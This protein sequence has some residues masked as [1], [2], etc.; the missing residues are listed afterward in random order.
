M[1]Y[2]TYFGY[3]ET[4]FELEK[5]TEEIKI[6]IVDNLSNKIVEFTLPATVIEQIGVT[7][8]HILFLDDARSGYIWLYKMKE[9]SLFVLPLGLPSEAGRD[10]E[11][12]LCL[13]PP[14]FLPFKNIT[15]KSRKMEENDNNDN[16]S[17]N[18]FEARFSHWEDY[19][20][21]GPN[22]PLS[23]PPARRLLACTSFGAF[24][25][26]NYRCVGCSLCSV[27]RCLY[28]NE[29][30]LFYDK[31][32]ENYDQE[33][34]N[35][36]IEKDPSSPYSFIKMP[37]HVRKLTAGND[38]L[39]LFN[40]LGHVYTL[41]TGTRGELGHGCIEQGQW[42]EPK[43]V[44]DLADAGIN[45]TDLSSSL[46]HNIALTDEGD[47]Y[48]WGWNGYGQL[49]ILPEECSIQPTPYPFDLPDILDEK[50]ESINCVG[51][52]SFIKFSNGKNFC[53]GELKKS[54]YMDSKELEG[55][56]STSTIKDF[57]SDDQPEMKRARHH[58]NLHVA[59][60]GCSHGQM[61]TIYE[62][63][64]NVEKQRNVKFD[65]LLCCG[66]FQ[67]IRNHG[68]LHYFHAPPHHRKLGTFYKYYSGEK[69]AP[70]LTLFIGGNHE[71]SGYMAELPY[72]GWVAPNIW[73]M[74][75]A[76]V[77]QFAGLR[78]AGL[79]GIFKSNDYNKGHF[80]RPPFQEHG[81]VVSAY[82]VRSI[83]V[84]RLK[85]L[86]DSKIDICMSHDWP[87]GITDFGDCNWLLK[88]KPYFA[89]D[90]QFN[91]LGNPATMNLLHELKPLHWFAAHLHVRFT[92]VVHHN[93]DDEEKGTQTDEIK[94]SIN[95]SRVTNFLALDKPMGNDNRRRFLEYIDI[96]ISED[97]SM[98]LCYD[99][100]WLAILRTTDHLTKFT[101]RFI[102]L[103]LETP[104]K[105]VEE[106]TERFD[107]RPT[108]EELE[109]VNTLFSSDFH[110]P[111][112]FQR[113][114]PPEI[115]PLIGKGKPNRQPSLYYRNPQSQQFCEKL[116]IQDLNFQFAQASVNYLGIPY[117]LSENTQLSISE[118]ISTKTTNE[119]TNNGKNP[120]EIDL[121]EDEFG[122]ND[123][124]VDVKG[125]LKNSEN[126]EK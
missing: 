121:E 46:W 26:I 105:N 79:S 124:I 116:G 67:A 50:V 30:P 73:Y 43:I 104:S 90:I 68:D 66:D 52:N 53:F 109:T 101:D 31:P 14:I 49:G 62:R 89:E 92:A 81:S 78:I 102:N 126:D 40:P 88:R 3:I 18:T 65:L 35:L 85:Q 61:D 94:S 59:V 75:Y 36:L 71:S 76:S 107:F 106:I 72:G 57:E 95:S 33:S 39:A 20:K 11:K 19:Q 119:S 108:K 37:F 99:P 4:D 6:T 44:S 13:K 91:R 64:T 47:I 96:P 2:L 21:L 125:S 17:L 8:Q 58:R 114:A 28:K 110:I 87:A 34:F 22:P 51:N 74:G 9:E 10:I 97:S 12:N 77:I 56:A 122:Q 15:I 54:S 45:V 117:F 70:I 86:R 41:G 38:H 16:I 55:D 69:T 32:V 103:P 23:S 60:A 83:D 80:E 123:F 115:E 63:L 98:E 1:K 29:S 42:T 118:E 27:L 93:K 120:E 7:E 82:H 112:N 113:T 84:F 100:I 111:L 5:P 25:A 24:L 48:G